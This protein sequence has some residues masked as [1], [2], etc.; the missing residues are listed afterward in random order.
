MPAPDV[1]GAPVGELAEELGLVAVGAA[2]LP[3]EP[4]AV[5]DAPGFANPI[6]PLAVRGPGGA[7]AIAPDPLRFP[8]PC[9]SQS[10]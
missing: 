8:S 2:A 5:P 6:T 3:L 7:V 4:P 1:A 10:Q 9:C